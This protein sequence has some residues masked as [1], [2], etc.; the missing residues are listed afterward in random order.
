MPAAGPATIRAQL[1]V[2]TGAGIASRLQAEKLK[3]SW[4]GSMRCYHDI[5]DERLWHTD[6]HDHPAVVQ[7]GGA[8]FEPSDVVP[9]QR[10]DKSGPLRSLGVDIVQRVMVLHSL[11]S[12]EVA[13]KLLC[14]RRLLCSFQSPQFRCGW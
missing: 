7:A 4:S 11:L 5:L 14:H 6:M 13:I 1:P 9:W 12:N 10:H 2:G 3:M 8:A